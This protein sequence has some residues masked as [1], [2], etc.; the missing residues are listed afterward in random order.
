[1]LLN[2]SVIVKYQL[3]ENVLLN[4]VNL[5][6]ILL[7]SLPVFAHYTNFSNV[8]FRHKS[9]KQILNQSINNDKISLL[10]S[11]LHRKQGESW[12]T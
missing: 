7:S 6:S 8:G 11:A 1:M 5:L 9:W 3:T 10:K 2:V 12:E 4:P